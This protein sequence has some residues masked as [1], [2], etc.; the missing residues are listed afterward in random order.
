MAI[1]IKPSSVAVEYVDINLL[2]PHPRNVEIYGDE[3][4]TALQQSIA[5]SGWIKPLTVTPIPDTN[6]QQ[7]MVIAGH[8]RH[9]CGKALGYTELPVIIEVFASPE[10]EMERLLRENENRGKTPEQQIREGMHWEP[11]EEGRAKKT[12]GTRTD[13]NLS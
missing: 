5:E 12:Q 8:R 2:K 4:I 3:D 10:A 7:Y 6:P 13:L 9:G 1:E 11:I